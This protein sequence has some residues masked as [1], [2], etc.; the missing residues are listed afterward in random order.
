M[1]KGIVAA[2]QA[3]EKGLSQTPIGH[4]QRMVNATSK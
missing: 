2:L 1:Q 3:N 4:G